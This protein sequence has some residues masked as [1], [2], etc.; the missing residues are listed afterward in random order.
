M[1]ALLAAAGFDVLAVVGQQP[2][3]VLTD[4]AREDEDTKAVYVARLPA[5]GRRPG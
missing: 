5:H 3:C 2:G 1:R 4:T